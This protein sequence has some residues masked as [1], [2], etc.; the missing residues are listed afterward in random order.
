MQNTIWNAVAGSMYQMQR[1]D[2][3]SNNLA[4][5][6]TDGFKAQDVTFSAYLAQIQQQRFAGARHG[7]K[8]IQD[9]MQV[10][11]NFA[12]GVVRN[13][14]NSMDVA[15]D[16]DGWFTIDTPEGTSYTRAGNFTLDAEGQLVTTSGHLVLG[17]GG[18]LQMDQALRPDLV[19]DEYG[20]L[21][22]EDQEVGRLQITHI[23]NPSTLRQAGDKLYRPS[24]ET[25]TQ[26]M[27]A[28]SVVQG[29]LEGSNVNLVKQ[30]V[31]IVQAGRSFEA[32]QRIISLVDKLNQQ[33][34]QQLANMPT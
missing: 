16:G 33:A 12:P 31:Q 8:S 6:N 25:Q 29:A 34:N 30:V 20:M 11:T 28:P 7:T 32:Y 2:V 21:Y 13:T 24:A 22:Q 3:V 1:L 19:F 18:P 17:E 27:E 15:I 5:A 4:N 9:Q 10:H 26:L 14:G 23:E